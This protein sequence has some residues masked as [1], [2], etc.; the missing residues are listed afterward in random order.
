MVIPP[1]PESA[2]Q[3]LRGALKE[4]GGKNFES[5]VASGAIEARN[6]ESRN[7]RKQRIAKSCKSAGT[8]NI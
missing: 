8:K 2:R 1:L 4:E 7:I 6:R 3:P 5:L